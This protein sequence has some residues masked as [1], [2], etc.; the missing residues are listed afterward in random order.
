MFPHQQ[1]F[2]KYK[3]FHTEN[4][5][6]LIFFTNCIF[7]KL[8]CANLVIDAGAD[9]TLEANQ[10]CSS[11]HQMVKGLDCADCLNSVAK[12]DSTTYIITIY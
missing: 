9:A 1:H 5:F 10:H 7:F 6:N 8:A 2:C 4:N 3:Y 11:H 12:T